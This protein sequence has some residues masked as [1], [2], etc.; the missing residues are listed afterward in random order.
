[1]MDHFHH[2]RQVALLLK[3]SGL[4][5]YQCKKFIGIYQIEIACQCKISGGNGISF[6]KGMAEFNI[7]FAL[8]A[9]AQMA[10]Q[11]F[12]HNGYMPFHKVRDV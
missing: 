1:M 6:D 9:I 5:I 7:V 3:F 2:G 10:Q 8:G 11:Q 4:N 12:A